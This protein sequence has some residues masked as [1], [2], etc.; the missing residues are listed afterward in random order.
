[1]KITLEEWKRELS[2]GIDEE[3]EHTSDPRVATQIALDHLREDAHYYT[4]LQACMPPKANPYRTEHAAR[5][6]APAHWK[7]CGRKTI[8]SKG[9]PITL[10][11]CSPTGRSA[12]DTEVASVRFPADRWTP[13][14]AREWLRDHGFDDSQ[15]EAARP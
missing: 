11:I 15:F 12:H 13:A 7:S 1:M 6:G 10:L 9:R 8:Q 2:M 3:L 5:Q 14:A 4:H